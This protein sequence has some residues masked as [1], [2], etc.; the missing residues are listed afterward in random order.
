MKKKFWV[1]GAAAC[2]LAAGILL[3]PPEAVEAGTLP[4]GITV[5][6]VDLTGMTG[7]EADQKI[8]QYVE[9][10]SNQEITL[11]I[12]GNEITTT[13][14]ELGFTWT[15]QEEIEETADRYA[16]GNLLERYLNLK[17]L[18]KEPLKLD[19]E[20]SVDAA[21]VAQFV[22]SKCSAFIRE[23]KD[24]EITRVNNAFQITESVV[25]LDVDIDATK[26]ALDEA[27]KGGL[28]EPVTI[29]AVVA[30][31][32]P[33][34]KSEDLAMIQDVLGTFS[35]NFSTGNISRSKNL[36]N[37]ASK[38]NGCVL[39]PGE[40]FSAYVYLTP[41]TI[42]NGYAAAGS[43]ENGRV[44][45][46]IGGGACQL[47]TTMYN[48]ALQAEMEI[49]QRQNHSMVV[50]YV[51]PS[52]D[53]AIA[54]TIKDLKF[55]NPYDAPIYIEGAVSGGT[56]TFTI[57]GKETR[58]ANREVK[59][60]SETLGASDPGAPTI[61]VDPSLRPGAKVLEQSAHRGMRSRLW[62]YVYVD[63]VE[64]E[65]EILHTDTY[66][67]SKA[68][69]R[70]GPE[71]PAVAPVLPPEQPAAPA[72]TQPAVPSGPASDG[73]H[74]RL[75]L[76][77]H[78]RLFRKHR[79]R[80]PHRKRLPRRQIPRLFRAARRPEPDYEGESHYCIRPDGSRT[81]FGGGRVHSVKRYIGRCN[82]KRKRTAA[83]LYA[84]IC[85]ALPEPIRNP[86]TVKAP[87]SFCFGRSRDFP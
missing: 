68:I 26:K 86:G 1:A 20:T 62:K 24:A 45:D 42:A 34:R 46:T 60:V 63:G 59:Y 35:T 44:V 25:G 55:K 81:G 83:A 7:E 79:L 71:L 61:K 85:K 38:V 30:E 66:M 82:T 53:A 11:T 5:G 6:G 74:R 77:R 39:M 47:C 69:Y 84:A 21:K 67:A 14:K 64:T 72:E 80:L 29:A 76:R 54:G 56:L 27:L 13:A 58:P 22:E 48:A 36:A 2:V 43:Y 50:G 40:E 32:Q 3:V 16:G 41:F 78:R 8:E 17:T 15:N 51:K 75:H 4:A 87:R 10:M 18:E 73:P 23:A 37:G 31:A 57:Y 19:V 52:Q 28:K 49:T 33:A 9:D 70:V 12:D 65:K